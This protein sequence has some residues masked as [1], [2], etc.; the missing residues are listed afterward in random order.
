MLQT[1]DSSDNLMLYS[2]T[3][4]PSTC[5]ISSQK[6]QHPLSSLANLY[7]IHSSPPTPLVYSLSKQK[8]NVGPRSKSQRNGMY[9]YKGS[10]IK[11]KKTSINIMYTESIP[12]V[13]DFSSPSIKEAKD[14]EDT[15]FDASFLTEKVKTGEEIEK[16]SFYKSLYESVQD[17]QLPS[18]SFSFI[19]QNNVLATIKF[20]F[21]VIGFNNSYSRKSHTTERV[22]EQIS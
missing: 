18:V 5:S 19:F 16:N 20:L 2:P 14:I 15:E 13:F 10:G 6:S 1:E 21:Y 11:A 22:F 12:N 9:S 17:G 8:E 3:N 7:G 4:S